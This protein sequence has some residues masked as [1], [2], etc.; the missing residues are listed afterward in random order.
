M[1]ARRDREREGVGNVRRTGSGS[2]GANSRRNNGLFIRL[3]SAR[4]CPA[5]PI[6]QPPL[7]PDGQKKLVL[8]LNYQLQPENS[9]FSAQLRR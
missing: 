4:R 3:T 1:I 2:S 7:W 5:P 9:C 8:A 6:D